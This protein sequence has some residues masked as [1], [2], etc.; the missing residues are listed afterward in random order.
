M[1]V[2]IP[3]QIAQYSGNH[4]R[5]NP[6]FVVG[7]FLDCAQIL[8]L[9]KFKLRDSHGNPY[10]ADKAMLQEPLATIYAD[11]HIVISEVSLSQRKKYIL[12][13]VRR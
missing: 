2:L 4:T 8:G 7:A 10:L 6:L 9:P 1:T 11:A 13:Y 5:F 12:S 3:L